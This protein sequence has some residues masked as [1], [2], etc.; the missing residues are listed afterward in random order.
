MKIRAA[1]KADL[2]EVFRLELGGFGEHGYPDFFIRQALDLWP[3]T[4]LV[5][6]SEAGLVG[7][8]LGSMGEAKEQGWILSL[9]VDERQRGMGIGKALLQRLL[10]ELAQRGCCEQR[11]TVHPNN[12]A[13]GLYRSLGFEFETEEP[14]YFGPG[15]PRQVLLR[16][17]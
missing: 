1:T 9:A 8:A 11:L 5:A 15:E 17:G 3:G 2:G 12:P 6:E 14:D 16:R 7:Y 10:A 4:L 13:A